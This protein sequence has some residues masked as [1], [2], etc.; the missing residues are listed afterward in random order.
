M[1][2][3][4]NLP[5]Q[6]V[7]G[8]SSPR[9]LGMFKELGLKFHSCS[10]EIEEARKEFESPEDYATRNSLEKAEAVVHQTKQ[11]GNRLILSADTIVVL[12]TQV[13]EK[14]IDSQDAKRMLRE[15][16]NKTHKVITAYTLQLISQDQTVK[17]ITE[18]QVTFVTFA[19]L[20]DADIDFYV[21]TGSPLD[22]AGSY[23]LQDAGNYLV[24]EI[25]GSHSNV[26]GLPMS[27]IIDDIK[28]MIVTYK[29]V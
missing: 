29:Q 7:I 20:S 17:K 25:K 18:H 13:L 22:K 27:E 9:R 24:K 5:F 3:L 19:E 14:P 23:G 6:L 12:G 4:L 11:L 28:K 2:P 8:S 21:S 1:T 16:S 26:I 10:P 15:M